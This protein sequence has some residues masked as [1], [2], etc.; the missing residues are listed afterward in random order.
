MADPFNDFRLEGKVALVTGAS[1]GIGEAVA[2]GLAAA[3]ARVV[4]SSRKQTAVDV[5]AA[6]I[7][8]HGGQAAAVAANAGSADDLNALVGRTVDAFGG[9]DILVNNAAANP[10]FGPSLQ[11]DGA[12]FDKIMGVNV[13]GPFELAKLAHPIMKTRGGGSIIN[14]SSI[15]GLSPE[16]GLGIYSVSKAALISLT[17]VLARE[18]GRDG[19]RVNAICPG[20]IKTKFSQ[21]LWQDEKN[22]TR[23]TKQLPLGRIGTPADMVG[24]FLLLASN[25][26]AYI[27]G[28]VFAADG[29]HTI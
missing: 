20:L 11:T 16:P 13:K 29:G 26:G 10:V 7:R 27:T 6:A 21:A 2:H 19:V 5:V 8:E 9:L 1:K 28:G 3:G 15:G 14:V 25:A 18:W 22:L 24:A 4:V 17:K 23:F 12:A